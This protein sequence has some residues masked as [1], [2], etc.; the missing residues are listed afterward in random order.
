[1]ADE[2]YYKFAVIS[3]KGIDI[4]K[5]DYYLQ[6]DTSQENEIIREYYP[7]RVIPKEFYFNNNRIS[8]YTLTQKEAKQI[9]SN[10]DVFEVE[11]YI[12]YDDYFLSSSDVTIVTSSTQTG[13]FSANLT[14][15][16][17]YIPFTYIAS[18]SIYNNQSANLNW[19]LRFHTQYTE[20]VD[21]EEMFSYNSLSQ[22]ITTSSTNYDYN[23]DGTGVDLVIL[24]TGVPPHP[25]FFNKDD[26]ISRVKQIDWYQYIKNFNPGWRDQPA[27]FYINNGGTH[28][29]H[30]ASIAAG[31]YSGWAKNADIYD[32]RVYGLG[33]GDFDEA[34][35]AIREFHLSKSID[36][37]TGFKRPTIVNYSSGWTITVLNFTSFTTSNV[38]NINQIYY[39]GVSQNLTGNNNIPGLQHNMRIQ[40]SGSGISPR[41]KWQIPY[42]NAVNNTLVEQ[43]TDA[44]VI[45]IKSAGN[46]N[47]ILTRNDTDLW[48]SYITRDT[49]LTIGGT[50]TPPNTPIW[51]NRADPHSEDSIIVGSIAPWPVWKGN[52]VSSSY[53]YNIIGW[54]RPN[55]IPSNQYWTIDPSWFVTPPGSFTA[56]RAIGSGSLFIGWDQLRI[57]A[58]ICPSEFT[59]VGPAVDIFAAGSFITAA[60]HQDGPKNYKLYDLLYNKNNYP[61]TTPALQE[62]ESFGVLSGTSM[63]A[64]QV[65]GVACLYFQMNPGATAKQFKQFLSA[66]AIKTPQMLVFDE[67]SFSRYDYS[68]SAP[69]PTGERYRASG[70]FLT[71]DVPFFRP[72]LA[73]NG[74]SPLILHWPYSN[75][76]PASFV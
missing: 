23:I 26:T 66:S 36:P 73:L 67:D 9:L 40:I 4:N 57:S 72:P 24:D 42:Y 5:I 25:E 34:C 17:D 62:T 50:P 60:Y 44:G 15:T 45:F 33:K 53:T 63:A 29:T 59:A 75:P 12:P 7:D 32:F 13:I 28:G 18:N 1:M 74:A 51:T 58:S 69:I 47:T 70:G 21:W 37:K 30:C 39:K 6:K 46:N 64:P 31:K 20:S 11:F 43:L 22:T 41:L 76:N 2:I 35:I 56:R 61:P 10:P 55:Y 16:N 14:S 38:T 65:A 49:N 48:D 3:K 54:N 52:L 19:G 27:N 71:T 68:G 8:L